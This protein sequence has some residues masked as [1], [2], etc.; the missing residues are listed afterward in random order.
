MIFWLD[1]HISPKLS[2]WIQ[3]AFGIEVLHLRD[4]ELGKAKDPDIFQRAREANAI[5]M[6]K[7]R[8][9]IDLLE[10]FGPPPKVIWLTCGN[11]SNAHLKMLLSTTLSAALKIVQQGEALVEISEVT[12]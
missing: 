2:P 8:D 9:F 12:H 11:S 1:V 4:M 3:D 10:R 5:M 6:T 7:D